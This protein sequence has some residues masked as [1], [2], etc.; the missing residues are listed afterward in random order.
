MPLWGSC[1]LL[2]RRTLLHHFQRNAWFEPRSLD[3][4]GRFQG[5][6][7]LLQLGWVL[8]LESCFPLILGNY[9]GSM[10]INYLS[11]GIPEKDTQVVTY[12]ASGSQ[13]FSIGQIEAVVP[14]MGSDASDEPNQGWIWAFMTT[15]R[16]NERH[17]P[18]TACNSFLHSL[19]W[20]MEAQ[21]GT[22]RS[23]MGIGRGSDFKPLLEYIY[24]VLCILTIFCGVFKSAMHLF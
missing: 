8:V 9:F 6:K 2:L 22:R 24:L 5:P 12:W 13:V 16:P 17:L 11:L 3:L 21:H 19:F 20:A 14:N 23:K 7:L 18:R 15:G 4:Q 10:L 1:F